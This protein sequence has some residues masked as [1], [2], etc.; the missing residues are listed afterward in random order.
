[1]GI[2]K[3]RA[4]GTQ[5]GEPFY[6]GAAPLVF[7]TINSGDGVGVTVGESGLEISLSGASSGQSGYSVT[8]GFADKPSASNYQWQ[9]GQGVDY[10]AQD[11][12]DEKVLVFSLGRDAHLVTDQPY[13]TNPS[14]LDITDVG[15]FGGK[16][17][18]NDVTSLFDFNFDFDATYNGTTTGLEGTTGRIDISDAIPGDQLRV[19]FD[20]EIIANINNTSIEPMLR[21]VSRD[22][23]GNLV[24]GGA[25]NLTAQ[26][27]FVG[28][29]LAGKTI[30]NRIEISAWINSEDDINALILPAIKAD[31]QLTIRPI[32]MMATIVR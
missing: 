16:H 19:R 10:S 12:L 22:S 15:L 30:L 21:F 17:L 13:W 28:T 1:V 2:F 32:T 20:F 14:P 6:N 18:P 24:P 7:H 3:G 26:P 11:A 8:G 29:G 23:D 5:A 4:L 25:F 9:A 31:Q 27:I